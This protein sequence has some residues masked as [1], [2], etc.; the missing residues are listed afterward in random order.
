MGALKKGERG[1]VINNSWSF[2]LDTGECPYLGGTM[3]T[4]GTKEVLVVS[5]PFKGAKD[6]EFVIVET[7]DKKKHIV[8]NHF[9]KTK[10][11][12]FTNSLGEEFYEGDEAYYYYAKGG[13]RISEGTIDYIAFPR[14][15]EYWSESYKSVEKAKEMLRR[16]QVEEHYKKGGKIQRHKSDGTWNDCGTVLPGWSPWWGR[17]DYRIKPEPKYRPFK[18]SEFTEVELLKG[19][20]RKDG[21]SVMLLGGVHNTPND[22]FENWTFLDG[23]PVGVE[24]E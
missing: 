2:T 9:K 22:L 7:E 14:G 19:I 24:I 17:C 18:M 13:S 12:I 11:L 23:S 10:K 20:K 4:P 21:G 3:A 1:I 6:Y 15:N 16:W 8:L 5:D